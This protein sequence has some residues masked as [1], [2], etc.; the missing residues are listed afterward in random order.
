MNCSPRARW[1]VDILHAVELV[2]S[3][4][5]HPVKPK[6]NKTFTLEDMLAKIEDV[7]ARLSC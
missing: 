7:Y 6:P 1:L 4:E 5:K 2:K 3:L